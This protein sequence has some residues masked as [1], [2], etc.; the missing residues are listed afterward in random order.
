[1][2]RKTRHSRWVQPLRAVQGRQSHRS[3]PDSEGK[4]ILDMIR[5][6]N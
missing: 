1:M 3:D 2:N 6:I 4:V 5:L